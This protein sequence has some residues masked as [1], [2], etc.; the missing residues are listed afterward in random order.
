MH[1]SAPV[2]PGRAER[3]APDAAASGPTGTRHAR[4]RLPELRA[5]P[6]LRERRLHA[7]RLPARLPAGGAD[8]LG[9][10][11]RGRRGHR[12]GRRQR[13]AALPQRRRG[14]CNWLVPAE[15]SASFCPACA[16]NRTIPDLGAARQPRAL[17]GARGGQAAADLCAAAARLPLGPGR[18]TPSTASPSTSSPTPAPSQPVM[19]GH[20]DGLITINIAEADSAER[21]RRRVELGEPYRTLLGHLRHEVGHYY[22]DVLVRDGG[23]LEAARAVFGDERDRLPGG[24][25]AA[26]PAGRA[27]QLAG[28]LR[29]RLRDDAPLGGLRRDLDPLSAHGRHPRHRR[30]LRPRRRR[31]RSP[32]TR[33]SRPRSPSTPTAPRDFDQLVEAWL[34]LTVAVNSLNRSMGQPDLY[35]FAL[36]PATIEKLRFIHADPGARR[37]AGRRSAVPLA[38]PRQPARR[39]ARRRAAPAASTSPARRP[40]PR[41]R[42]RRCAAG[43]RRAGRRSP[44]SAPRSGRRACRAR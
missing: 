4:L 35:P 3:S 12:H 33:R 22:W 1:A 14:A 13:L 2:R 9:A 24:A 39:R 41:R 38:P 26:L 21:E 18:R 31:R 37:R 30:E 17:A 25:A 8:P 40:G 29:Q 36:T 6:A 16:L 34:P 44:A 5:A 32:T 23:Q 10:G 15:D 19:T 43:C 20:D 7:L 42:A 27:G 28:E 11:A